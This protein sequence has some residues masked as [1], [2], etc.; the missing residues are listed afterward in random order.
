LKAEKEKEGRK[1]EERR[2][3]IEEADLSKKSEI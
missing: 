3:K 1:K 2:D